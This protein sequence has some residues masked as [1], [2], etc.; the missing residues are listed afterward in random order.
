MQV[1]MYEL[2]NAWGRNGLITHV[3]KMQTDYKSRAAIVQEAAGLFLI[4]HI[5]CFQLAFSCI[6]RNIAQCM[7]QSAWYANKCIACC[8]TSSYLF[9]MPTVPMTLF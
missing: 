7:H 2:L 4:C 1:V 3:K 5:C 9:V 8:D 6:K